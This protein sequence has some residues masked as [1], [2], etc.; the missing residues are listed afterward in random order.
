MAETAGPLPKPSFWTIIPP[1]IW[2][3]LFLLIGWGAGAALNLPVLYRSA[4]VGG[5]VAAA[6]FAFALWGRLTFASVGAE[7]RPASPVNSTLVINGPFRFTR[8]P[9]YLGIL[10][11]LTGLCLLIGTATALLAVPV[12]FLFVNFVSIPYEEEKMERQFGDDYRAYKSRVR[13][14]L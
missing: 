14:W 10:I 9:M 11:L 3:L 4:A 12:Y 13:R 5:T 8:N 7:I 2:A 6:G 1:P